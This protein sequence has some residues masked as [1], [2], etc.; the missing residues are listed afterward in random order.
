MASKTPENGNDQGSIQITKKIV[1][2]KKKL[3][4]AGTYFSIFVNVNKI[5]YKFTEGQKKAYIG[6]WTLRD[7]T[8]SDLVTEL[9]KDIKDLTGKLTYLNNINSRKNVENPQEVIRKIPY[10]PGAKTAEEA[11]QII[12]LKVR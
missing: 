11:V 8:N 4:L 10:P 7:K 6:E 5:K 2:L 3:L 12:D 1:E 9:K